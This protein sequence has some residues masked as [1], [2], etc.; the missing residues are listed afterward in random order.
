MEVYLKAKQPNM[1]KYLM[2]RHLIAEI[3]E[4]DNEDTEYCH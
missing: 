2:E 1:Y 4:E 3:M